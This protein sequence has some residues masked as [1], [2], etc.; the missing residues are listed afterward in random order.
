MTHPDV[1]SI[2]PERITEYITS[3]FDGVEVLTVPSGSGTFFSC[4]DAN[5]PNF[6]TLVTSD[7][8]DQF[9]EL[10]RPGVYRL[11]IGLTRKTF[12]SLFP[13]EA[14]HDYTA[15]DRLM[16]HPEYSRQRWV[17]VLNPSQATFER[18]VKPLLEE[19]YELEMARIE[20]R[21]H[22]AP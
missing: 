10:A 17:S 1:P 19:A 15:L 14:E 7:E 18:V 12:E 3:T 9:S 2:T 20:R 4:S 8:Y 16:P 21:K 22:G 13:T 6:A 5:W 11:N